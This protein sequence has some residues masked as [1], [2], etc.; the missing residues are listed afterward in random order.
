MSE[1]RK[2]L[3]VSAIE[4]GT[5]IDHI[6]ADKLFLVIKILGLEEFKKPVTFG[7]NLESKKLGRK[8]IIK[9]QDK[10]F[11]DHE[12]RKIALAAPKATLI[13]I[14]NY[15]VVEKRKVDLPDHFSGIVK[16]VN[17]K[18]ITNNQNVMQKFDLIDKEAVKLH[19]H[20]CE[21]ITKKENFE[22]L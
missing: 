21:K 16:C 6:P 2:E 1:K 7:A 20:Y 14:K 17:P 11:Q 18:C 5:V 12:I 3:V 10:F 19:C 9:V 15:E 22:F 4:N 8:G 13:V